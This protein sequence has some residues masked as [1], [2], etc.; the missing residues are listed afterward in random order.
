MAIRINVEKSSQ[1][2]NRIG[3][4]NRKLNKEDKTNDLL[5]LD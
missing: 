3:C 1:C 5:L 4:A 2:Q